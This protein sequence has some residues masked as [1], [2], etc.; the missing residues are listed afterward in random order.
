MNP[1]TPLPNEW[2]KK[3]IR[4]LK[5]GNPNNIRWSKRAL[6]DWSMYGL[7]YEAYSYLIRQLE[8][9]DIW[10][11]SNPDMDP[12]PGPPA[13]IHSTYEFLCPH[14]LNPKSNVYAKIALYKDEITIDVFS[15][16]QDHTGKLGAEIEEAK[17]KRE[18][19]EQ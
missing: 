17:A 13:D 18:E 11:K 4:I 16:H 19:A 5:L 1:V 3:V 2:C 7:E 12:L 8:K 9:R 14:P 15:L 10:G 6:Q